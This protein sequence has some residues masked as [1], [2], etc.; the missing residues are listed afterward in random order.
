MQRNVNS[1]NEIQAITHE[2]AACLYKN[3]MKDWYSEDEI[4]AQLRELTKETRK[5]RSG[6]DAMLRP[7][8][9]LTPRAV[10]NDRGARKP[11][12]AEPAPEGTPRRPPEKQK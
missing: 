3:T 10:V 11:Q 7:S 12:P 4:K 1:T 2:S 9:T 6:L 8:K 5:L